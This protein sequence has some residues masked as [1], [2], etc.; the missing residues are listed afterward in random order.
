M[1]SRNQLQDELV[2]LIE[3]ESEAERQ[4]AQ[5]MPVANTKSPGVLAQIEFMTRQ[6]RE[7]ISRCQIALSKAVRERIEKQRE[8]AALTN[9][10]RM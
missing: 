3:R 6:R 1:T 8:L 2:Q 4:L 10:G 9:A 7:S 5:V